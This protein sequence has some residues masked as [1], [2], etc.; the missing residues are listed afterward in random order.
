MFLLPPSVRCRTIYGRLYVSKLIRRLS[1]PHSVKFRRSKWGNWRVWRTDYP[2]TVSA[3]MELPE[4]AGPDTRAARLAAAL[5][6]DV[7][8]LI[9]RSLHYTDLRNLA[10]AARP[11]RQAIFPIGDSERRAQLRTY[12]CPGDSPQPCASC[13]V[14][15]CVSRSGF[16]TLQSWSAHGS[17]VRN[18]RNDLAFEGCGQMRYNL[19][20][21]GMHH[22]RHCI[23]RYS[24]CALNAIQRHERSPERSSQLQCS[25][26]STRHRM[27]SETRR[28]CRYCSRLDRQE[29][30]SRLKKSDEVQVQ[31]Q[32]RVRPTTCATFQVA[33]PLREP[34][35]WECTLCGRECKSDVHPPWA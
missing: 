22:L 10:L 34:R 2:S 32:R 6:F 20:Q 14:K 23:P 17:D 16:G 3:L 26:R 30:R 8:V 5:P 21:W 19:S 27:S 12:T 4:R 18:G 25:C 24:A 29:L 9:A 13:G 31:R 7:L 28:L 33:L 15:T 1:S 35:W 11:L